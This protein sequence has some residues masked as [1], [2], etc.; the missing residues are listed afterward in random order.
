MKNQ[1]LFSFLRLASVP[2]HS[3]ESHP[4]ALKLLCNVGVAPESAGTRSIRS[5][6][7]AL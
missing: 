2:V 4:D 1:S 6:A 3:M 5:G 7:M